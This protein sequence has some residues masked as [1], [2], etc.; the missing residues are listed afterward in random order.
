MD[1]Y[2]LKE[3]ATFCNVGSHQE[4]EG[5]TLREHVEC[6]MG[7]EKHRAIYLTCYVNRRTDAFTKKESCEEPLSLT[8]HKDITHC[9]SDRITID[10]Q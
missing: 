4:E 6:K 10:L 7:S 2:T 3:K 5:L 8:S 9:S 1:T